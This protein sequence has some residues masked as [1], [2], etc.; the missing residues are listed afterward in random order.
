MTIRKTDDIQVLSAEAGLDL[1]QP[2][3]AEAQ[4]NLAALVEIPLQALEADIYPLLA[5]RGFDDI[6]P[7]HSKVFTVIS[8]AGS[9]VTD[10][11]AAAAMTKQAMQ[12]LVDDLEQLGYAERIPDPHDRRAKLIRLTPQG[13]AVVLVA[14]ESIAATEGKWALRIGVEQMTELR[15][16]L[17]LLTKGLL[18]QQ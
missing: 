13:R 1:T 6:R 3:P 11:A 2:L 9:R 10:M 8:G 18:A 4:F 12:Y 17:E 16:L 5:E 14:R 15:R 7:A